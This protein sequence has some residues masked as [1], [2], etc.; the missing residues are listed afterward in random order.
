MTGETILTVVDE[1]FLKFEGSTVF[2]W[3]ENNEFLKVIGKFGALAGLFSPS[4]D[5]NG[6]DQVSGA[7]EFDFAEKTLEGSAK[8]DI[9][10]PDL[11]FFNSISNL[12]LAGQLVASAQFSFSY[13]DDGIN[14][15]DFI[16]AYGLLDLGAGNI[17][18][19]F[20]YNFDNSYEILEKRPD[21]LVSSNPTSELAARSLSSTSFLTAAASSSFIVASASATLAQNINVSGFE[22]T[23]EVESNLDFIILNVLWDDTSSPVTPPQV[24]VEIL[25]PNGNVINE[26]D[27]DQYE[28]IQVIEKL[29]AANH[30]AIGIKN[31]S[32][33]E[34]GIRIANKTELEISEVQTS[35]YRPIKNIDPTIEILD[36][37]QNADGS[38][39]T[40][41]YEARDPDTNATFDLYYQADN[42][43]YDFFDSET[44]ASDLPEEDGI[45][46]YVWN[47]QGIKPGEYYILG[48]ITGQHGILN[49][50]SDY[51]SA[52]ITITR[53]ADLSID[54]SA[55]VAREAIVGENITYTA[56]VTNNSEDVEAK[57]V[58]VYITIPRDFELVSTSIPAISTE[59]RRQQGLGDIELNIGQLAPGAS[60][61]VEIILDPA[62]SS[63][64]SGRTWATVKS[65]T[66]DP[67]ADNYRD[68]VFISI[69]EPPVL[70]PFVTVERIDRN[71]EGERIEPETRIEIARDEPYTYEV[72]V[73]NTGEGTATGVTITE[74][75]AD[76]AHQL[77]QIIPSQ[78]DYSI[79]PQTGEITVNFGEIAPG[80]TE[81]VSITIIPDKAYKTSSTSALQYNEKKVIDYLT[82]NIKV[83][84]PPVEPADLELSQTVDNPTPL[85]GEEVNITLTLVNKGPGVAGMTEV[86]NLLPDG[87]S[88]VRASAALGTYDPDT[89]IW[90]SGNIRDGAT[91]SL[92]I[93]ALVEEVGNLVNQAEI[94]SNNQQDPDSTPGNGEVG[95]DD[96]TTITIKGIGIATDEDTPLTILAAELLS[97]ATGDNLSITEIIN[98]VNGTAVINS[99]G[100]VEFAPDAN[101]YGAASFDYTVT[102]GTNTSTLSADVLVRSVNDILIANDDTASTDEDTPVTIFASTLFDNDINEDRKDSRIDDISNV[103]SGTAII[104]SDGDIEFTPDLDFNGIA[105]FDYTVTDGID[106]ETASVRVTVNAVNDVPV[107]KDDTFTIDEDT[108]LTILATDLLSN[109][110]D[111]ETLESLSITKVENAVNGTVSLG[112]EGDIQFFP[113]ANFNETA[114]FNYIVSD[115]TDYSTASVEVVINPVNDVLIANN[116]T[117]TAN[118]DTLTTILASKL[119]ANDVNDDIEKS[120]NISQITNAVNGT[121]II[122][123]DGNVEFTPDAHFYGT[124]SFDYTVTDG[125]DIETASVEVLVNSVDDAPIGNNDIATTDED[126]PITILATE[127][128]SNDINYDPEDSLS[129]VGVGNSV[130]GTAIINSDGNIEFAPDAN[131]YGTASFDYTVTDGKIDTTASVAVS[132]AP[133]NDPLVLTT[134]IPNITVGQNAPNSV[135]V[136]SD[137]FEDIEDDDNNIVY[138]ISYSASYYGGGDKFFDVFEYDSPT[139]SLTLGYIDG[140]TG[141]ATFTITATDRRDASVETSF[142]V[143]VED[144][145]VETG[146]NNSS[147]AQSRIGKDT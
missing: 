73:T 6:V 140:I 79:D 110:T 54:L 90:N 28:N 93:T 75:F 2:S 16:R 37:S 3:E 33:G 119:F 115:G 128:L 21:L 124:A 144:T 108:P 14:S 41:T 52:P 46:T 86:T 72:A 45:G 18:A 35:I 62:D 74:S 135:I 133:V 23:H 80:E 103:N 7:I 39:V 118:E 60:Q 4:K 102:D 112:E 67:N 114:S 42:E 87:L 27:F 104:N 53:E 13:S 47:T 17:G 43:G 127:L 30:K 70:K 32:L 139:K 24:Q 49:L 123:S 25:D 31:P 19:G 10:F 48:Q 36:V 22:E 38:E 55:N 44:I 69:V 137:Y 130:N 51:S 65:A 95:E 136:L 99:D 20:Q 120:L 68:D 100:N 76:S 113:D 89:G 85:L 109:D 34:W 142:N 92:T 147:F 126:T 40:I 1:N 117:V 116:D 50:D 78:G 63:E 134:P 121:A 129:I 131:F 83:N 81:T 111:V 56:T 29:S 91:T 145:V 141:T 57:D 106:R 107:A 66:Y 59:G 58:N 5:E 122:N 12:P 138:N 26:V 146:L 88:F 97:A 105:T 132:V 77:G 71:A 101:F 143:T 8:V 98:P 84:L 64:I 9:A 96:F 15:N 61:T 94:T 125:T 82:T 11:P